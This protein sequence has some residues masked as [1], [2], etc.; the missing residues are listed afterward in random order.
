MWIED[1]KKV[2]D[3]LAEK[4]GTY[5]FCIDK[6]E[7]NFIYLSNDERIPFRDLM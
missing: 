4:Y 1:I 6:I 2:L 5:S 7:N 3:S